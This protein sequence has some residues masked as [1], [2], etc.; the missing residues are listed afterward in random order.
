M[1]RFVVLD[2]FQYTM[3]KPYGAIAGEGSDDPQSGDQRNWTLGRQQYDWFK[4]TL[5]GSGAKFKFG[6]SDHVTGGQLSV[7]GAGG[8]RAMYVAVQRPRLTSN[9]VD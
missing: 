5:E 8:R 1:A 3:A 6:F 7:S 2:P 4:Q 9:G